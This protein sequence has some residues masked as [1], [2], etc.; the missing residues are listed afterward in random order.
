MIAL[1]CFNHNSITRSMSEL[2]LWGTS[3]YLPAQL[4]TL[5]ED[6]SEDQGTWAMINQYW[7]RCFM[8][9]LGKGQQEAWDVRTCMLYA[10]YGT[11]WLTHSPYWSIRHS[12]KSVWRGRKKSGSPCWTMSISHCNVVFNQGETW[13][14][15]KPVLP[16]MYCPAELADEYFHG[17]KS[18]TYSTAFHLM[19]RVTNVTYASKTVSLL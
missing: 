17:P 19:T 2:R 18:P 15:I 6:V 8:R 16:D 13:G 12:S 14:K 4:W 3:K 1:S 5:R 10:F 7:R 11:A 9:P